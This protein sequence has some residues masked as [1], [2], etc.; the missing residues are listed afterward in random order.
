MVY[1]AGID[2]GK[3]KSRVKVIT[4]KTKIVDDL[5]IDNDPKEFARISRK[6]KGEIIAGCRCDLQRF[7]G[8]RYAGA[9]SP[10]VSGGTHGQDPL[11]REAK[12]KTD[13]LD[14]GILAELVRADLFPSIA[15][16][17]GGSGISES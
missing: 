15:I 4:G 11:D 13:E 14:A 3:R 16:P 7:L 17:P 8:G 10:E 1:Y 12:I 9:I 6:N 2:L 5:K